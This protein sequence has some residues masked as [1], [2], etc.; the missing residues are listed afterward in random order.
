MALEDQAALDDYTYY[1]AGCVGEFWTAVTA[2]HVPALQ[3]LLAPELLAR[4]VALGR[5]LQLVNVV[6][7][8]AADLRAGR[9]YW[10]RA[11]LALHNT[12]GAA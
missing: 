12:E 10:P 5:C 3:P 4:G 2:A 9:C 6:R 7:D 8:A 11:A 1:A